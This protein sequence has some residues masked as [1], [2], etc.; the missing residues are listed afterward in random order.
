MK[1]WRL[2]SQFS[3]LLSSMI[4]TIGAGL[5]LTADP[6][7]AELEEDLDLAFVMAVSLLTFG[8]VLPLPA[9]MPRPNDIKLQFE[10][11]RL[12]RL[13]TSLETIMAR[14]TRM[15]MECELACE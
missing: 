2:P 9:R 3:L 4:S 8:P 5:R 11:V 14:Q 6:T 13:V 1:S 15:G 7:G 12:Q 10:L